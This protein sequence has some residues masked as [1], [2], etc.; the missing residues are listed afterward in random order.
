MS[1]TLG[2]SA[3]RRGGI[4]RR[5]A[6]AHITSWNECLKPADRSQRH[7]LMVWQMRK[8]HFSSPPH[9]Q[10]NPEPCITSERQ[11]FMMIFFFF[12]LLQIIKTFRRKWLLWEE[13]EAT[14]FSFSSDTTLAD[15]LG[16]DIVY[17]N[18]SSRVII[19]LFCCIW[20]CGFSFLRLCGAGFM[21]FFLLVHLKPFRNNISE[22]RRQQ[23]STWKCSD[24]YSTFDKEGSILYVHECLSVQCDKDVRYNV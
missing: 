18:V 24:K 20:H 13:V 21:S 1:A 7:C 6:V 23:Q 5:G 22:K 4:W 2:C 10:T 16:R 11:R 8:C 12:L 3:A 19:Q 15:H 9:T 17:S 14:S